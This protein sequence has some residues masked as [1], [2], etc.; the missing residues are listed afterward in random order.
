[1]QAEPEPERGRL[2][3][4]LTSPD[5]SAVR[6]AQLELFLSQYFQ[7]HA[8]S[9]DRHPPV[10]DTR[11]RP[12]Y[13]VHH[14]EASFY[15]EAKVGE[16][17]QVEQTQEQFRRELQDALRPVCG[18][19]HIIVTVL[20]PIPSGVSQRDVRMFLT[21]KLDKLSFS[22]TSEEV[23][24]CYHSS[25]GRPTLTI[26]FEVMRSDKV[27]PVIKGWS[28]TGDTAREVTTHET[29]TDSIR[30]KASRYGHLG[31]P[32]IVAAKLDTQSPITGSSAARALYGEQHVHIGRSPTGGRIVGTSRARSGVFTSADTDGNPIGTRVSAVAIYRHTIPPGTSGTNIHD[33]VLYHNPFAIYPLP[34]TILADIPQCVVE[35]EAPDSFRLD[36]TTSPPDWARE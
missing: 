27:G 7:S 23:T 32:F 28:L 4:D 13:L 1:M 6:A 22:D 9:V 24:L 14:R 34:A 3:A 35:S 26:R 11:R 5:D 30:K 19:F 17:S 21:K 16:D 36:W 33:L 12:D 8:W 10:P 29:L 2:A 20:T 18:P 15:V 31:R 25:P